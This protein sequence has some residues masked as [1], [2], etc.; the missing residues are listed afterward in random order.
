MACLGF[1]GF[2]V[3]GLLGFGGLGSDIWVGLESECRPECAALGVSRFRCPGF[4]RCSFM[5]LWLG[6]SS[7][8]CL[9]GLYGPFKLSMGHAASVRFRN[10]ILLILIF[11]FCV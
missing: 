10:V 11:A 7:L 3:W 5:C 1:L 2:G 8:E 9:E 4:S 6:F